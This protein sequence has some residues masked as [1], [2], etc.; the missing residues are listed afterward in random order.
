MAV[1][2]FS[3]QPAARGK[4][5]FL[6][7]DAAGK[8]R[9]QFVSI[10]VNAAISL[11]VA[12]DADFHELIEWGTIALASPRDSL[13]LVSERAPVGKSL[14]TDPLQTRVR[15]HRTHFRLGEALFQPGAK[16]VQSV[17]AHL[18]EAAVAVRG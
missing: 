6:R 15:H 7:F 18:I 9:R 16:A 4:P 13:L 2:E 14:K 12:K 17:V 3:P 1:E 10:A 5:D 11:E 8:A